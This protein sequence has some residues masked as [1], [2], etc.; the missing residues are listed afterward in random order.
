MEFSRRSLKLPKPLPMLPQLQPGDRPRLSLHRSRDSD[1]RSMCCTSMS[2]CQ[3][4][5]SHHFFSA[6]CTRQ[7]RSGRFRGER[8]GPAGLDVRRL[9]TTEVLGPA[10]M[11]V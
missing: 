10:L 9:P 8:R 11:L 3:S 1:S 5:G 2:R 6:S 4:W 7:E